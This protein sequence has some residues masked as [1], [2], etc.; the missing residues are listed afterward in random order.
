M[1]TSNQHEDKIQYLADILSFVAVVGRMDSA[2]M[3]LVLASLGSQLAGLKPPE[4]IDPKLA[5]QLVAEIA[6]KAGRKVAA[7]VT[8][9]L[10]FVGSAWRS[11][12]EEFGPFDPYEELP[13]ADIIFALVNH[14]GTAFASHHI[15]TRFGGEDLLI[16][17]TQ[18]TAALKTHSVPKPGLTWQMIGFL[19]PTDQALIAIDENIMYLFKSAPGPNTLRFS[20]LDRQSM[21]HPRHEHDVPVNQPLFA[22]FV[23][24]LASDMIFY[25]AK[26][27]N[28]NAAGHEI[29]QR[30][31][32]LLGGEKSPDPRS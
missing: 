21:D 30:L 11:V 17:M 3:Q 12:L 32:V 24:G 23:A 7:E 2:V 22:A 20:E 19:E 14:T 8:N 26:L 10:S 6:G 25:A 1:S 31:L 15:I 16:P 28:Q 18:L 29:W 13:Y 27:R 9:D 5:A 4:P